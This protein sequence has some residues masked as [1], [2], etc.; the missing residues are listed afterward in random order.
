M[1]YKVDYRDLD[2]LDRYL[3]VISERSVGIA[4]QMVYVGAGEVAD[5]VRA[6]LNS[7]LSDEATGR[8]AKSLD[9]T[10]MKDASDAVYNN[11]TFV[12]YDPE[13]GEP[14]PLIAAVLE[15]GRS[16]QPGRR[17]THF[18]SRAVRASRL[19]AEGKMKQKFEELLEKSM[20][21]K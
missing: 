16:D 14:F 9:I 19:R 15:S 7:V 6:S 17:P 4:K 13:T 3:E 18:Y 20:K 21:E 11:Q 10:K 2:R 1:S 5:A 12:G 8:L